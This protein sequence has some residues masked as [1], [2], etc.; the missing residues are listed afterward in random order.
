MRVKFKP[1][2][3]GYRLF[4]RFDP[5]VNGNGGGGGGNGG[6]DSATV[7]DSTGHPVLV[8]SDPVTATNAANRDYAQ[9]VFA[10]LDGSFGE[11]SS[12]FVGASSDGLV[13]LDVSH[14]LTDTYADAFGGNVVQTARLV[15]DDGG[16]T[17]LALG[18]GSSQEEAVG[19]DD[20]AAE[21]VSVDACSRGRPPEPARFPGL[22]SGYWVAESLST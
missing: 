12:G 9:P 15:L 3:P 22:R 7:D 19:L 14:A 8:S 18:F 20:V 16:Q 1:R 13:Q 10:A 2:D 4:V 21:S 17:V 6:A 11:A 5:T